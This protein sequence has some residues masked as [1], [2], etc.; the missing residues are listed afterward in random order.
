M[1]KVR[2]FNEVN[3]EVMEEEEKVENPI[4]TESKKAKA[5]KVIKTVAYG[6]AF[7]AGAGI[8]FVLSHLGDKDDEK[9]EK[10]DDPTLDDIT[11]Q[12][13][14]AAKEDPNIDTTVF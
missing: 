4:P 10:K 14:E 12:F 11:D 8:V 13:V 5:W 1:A 6:V 2:N 7:I 9:E 3:E